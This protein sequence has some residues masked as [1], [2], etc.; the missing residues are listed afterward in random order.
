M[1]VTANKQFCSLLDGSQSEQTVAKLHMLQSKISFH[2]EL[3]YQQPDKSKS[4]I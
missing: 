3:Y 2:L 4:N 1:W